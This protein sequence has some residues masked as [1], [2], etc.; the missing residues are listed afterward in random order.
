MVGCGSLFIIRPIVVRD[1]FTSSLKCVITEEYRETS[2]KLTA[3]DNQY[4]R[5]LARHNTMSET[6]VLKQNIT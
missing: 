4:Q 6:M 2:E 3:E 5:H 1:H